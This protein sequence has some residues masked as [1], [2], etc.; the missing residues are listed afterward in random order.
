MHICHQEFIAIATV[1]S[2][3]DLIVFYAQYHFEQLKT[4]SFSK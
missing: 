1:L 3:F 2:Q 4:F